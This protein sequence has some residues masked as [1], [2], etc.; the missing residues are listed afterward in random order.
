MINC[1]KTVAGVKITLRRLYFITQKFFIFS[2]WCKCRSCCL[3][4]YNPSESVLIPVRDELQRTDQRLPRSCGCQSDQ[5]CSKT[6]KT[7][8]CHKRETCR[9]SGG[10]V[11]SRRTSVYRGWNRKVLCP[12]GSPFFCFQSRL[13]KLP[14]GCLQPLNV[15]YLPEG[16]ASRWGRIRWLSHT[17]R[18][19][20]IHLHPAQWWSYL[21]V[22][23]QLAR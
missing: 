16:A 10:A 11:C 8:K 14:G 22:M 13:I 15:K 12:C 23:L 5:L 3:L 1:S 4:L 20:Q 9:I 21:V 7:P 2:L 19:G 18:F 17:H 6:A